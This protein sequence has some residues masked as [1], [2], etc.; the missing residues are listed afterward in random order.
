MVMHVVHQL[1]VSSLKSLV[2]SLQQL[3]SPAWIYSNSEGCKCD[4]STPIHMV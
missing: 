4:Q 1:G 2:S 3:P